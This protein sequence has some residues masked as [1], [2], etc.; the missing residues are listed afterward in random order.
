MKKNRKTK[1]L[2]TKPKPATD[3]IRDT[4]D[5][6]A[7]WLEARLAEAEKEAKALPI[8]K[9]APLL[10]ATADYHQELAESADE[11]SA[12]ACRFQAAAIWRAA[13]MIET[14]EPYFPKVPL[15]DLASA[16]AYKC[17]KGDTPI[18]EGEAVAILLANAIRDLG[19]Y[20]QVWLPT[21][22]ADY[23]QDGEELTDEELEEIFRKMN[24]YDDRAMES[25][26][27]LL[28]SLVDEVIN[29]RKKGGAQ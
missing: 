4:M 2:G 5:T 1:R 8:A 17:R 7:D 9:L 19:F 22:A 10:R 29:D 12:Q 13:D 18:A 23:T 27:E 21:D 28:E 25:N 16:L 15:A 24:K 3:G 26:G 20:A 6:A 11:D 14:P